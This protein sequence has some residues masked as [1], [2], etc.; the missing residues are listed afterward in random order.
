MYIA[1]RYIGRTFAPGDVL[2]DDFPAD[3]IAWFLKAGAVIERAEEETGEAANAAADREV[4]STDSQEDVRSIIKGESGD[5]D[6][7]LVLDVADEV[8][9]DE[10]KPRKSSGR[11][12][13]K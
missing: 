1:T 11:R 10:A 2:P 7:E 5:E 12:K 4:L 6:D 8:V 9:I 3:K 13:G